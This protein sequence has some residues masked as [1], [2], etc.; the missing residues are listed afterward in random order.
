M[1]GRPQTAQC[2]IRISDFFLRIFGG[3]KFGEFSGDK[4]SSANSDIGGGGLVYKFSYRA[5]VMITVRYGT[6]RYGTVRYNTIRYDTMQYSTV[7]YN[8]IQYNTVQYNTIRYNFCG[9]S[10]EENSA[11]FRGTKIRRLIRT[12]A[13]AA[14]CISLV[15]AY[16]DSL[17]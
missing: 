1:T 17:V 10:V 16:F 13:E 8:T 7:Q 12:S 9:F 3:G 2:K 11:S 6:V 14:W 15:Y 4:N 5:A